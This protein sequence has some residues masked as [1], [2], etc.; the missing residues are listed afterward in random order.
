[1]GV[2]HRDTEIT[3]KNDETLNSKAFNH[4]NV[5]KGDLEMRRR[6]GDTVERFL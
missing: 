3:E 2:H 4:A 6:Y 1:V 5:L